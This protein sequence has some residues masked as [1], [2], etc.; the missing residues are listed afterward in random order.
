[1]PSP[2]SPEY[3][4]L[5]D[6]GG[7]P[8]ASP[9]FNP[10]HALVSGGKINYRNPQNPYG[11]AA[12]HAYRMN[13]RS[14][15]LSWG[16][17]VGGKPSKEEFALL[18]SEVDKIKQQFPNIKV[19]SHGEAYAQTKGTGSQASRAGRGLEEAS[20]RKYLFGDQPYEPGTVE[21]LPMKMRSLTAVAGVQQTQ[22]STTGEPQPMAQYKNVGGV[23][24]TAPQEV[25]RQQALAKALMMGGMDQ[26][27]PR[28]W[29]EA[30]GNVLMSGVGMYK[31]K[32]AAD[33][34]AKGQASGNEALAQM[35][36][37]G[38]ASAAMANPY[39]AEQAMAYQMKQNDPERQLRM[40][41]LR[42]ELAQPGGGDMPSNI[43]EWEYFNKLPKDQQQQYLNMKR[44]IPFLDRGP[45]FMQ[46]NIV[47]PTQPGTV[48][49]KN[50][51]E[52]ERQEKVGAAMG[53]GQLQLP[54][55]AT[56]LQQYEVQQDVVRQDIDRAIQTAKS[57][58]ATTGMGGAI[59]R[60]IP[61]TSAYDLSQTLNTIKGN[62]GFDKLQNMRENSPTGG[63]LG[64]VAVQ[65]L[66]ML[67]SVFG[68]LSQSQSSDQFIANLE[69]LKQIQDKFRAMKREAYQ[70]D[71]ARFGS[72]AVPNPETGAPAP[73]APTA[74]ARP[75]PLGLF[76]GAGS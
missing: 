40:E 48:V 27:A 10:Y 53:E 8:G 14:I 72:A 41:K 74:P 50:I 68:A 39:S 67:Q 38:D 66:E 54:K 62:I 20:W 15:G 11:E 12:P 69:R 24:V 59:A 58:T 4:I 28:H 55:T 22:P 30:L 47:D 44:S 18:K 60:N 52:R 57:G 17:P 73:S 45:D 1:M 61:G 5:H 25:Q 42:K 13:P 3:L 75:D 32:Q 9:S 26:S 71:V 33:M 64:Q 19:L 29:S 36:M 65:E 63:A 56:A 37:G 49:P 6:Y 51:V 23:P 7:T 70:R 16:G 43:K 46:P 21:P 35:L 2:F 34:E 31:G 76:G